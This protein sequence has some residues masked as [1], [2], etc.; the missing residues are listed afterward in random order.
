ME[1]LNRLK[2]DKATRKKLLI[3]MSIMFA[4]LIGC[5]I[6]L[7][8]INTEYLHML[9]SAFSS[10]AGGIVNAITGGSFS[11]MSVFALSVTPYITA[12]ILLQ[13]LTVI[14]PSLEKLSKS[15]S[16]GTQKMEKITL[17]ITGV[18]AVIE[19]I[20]L[21]V[22]LGKNGLFNTYNAWTVVYATVVWTIGACVLVWV[23]QMITKKFIGNGISLILLFNIL[24]TLP[25]EVMNI[26][27]YFA[28]EAS[29]E[30]QI[31]IAV[32]IAV[33]FIL[34]IAYV[35]V[36]NNAEE[37][38]HITNAN[39]SGFRMTSANDNIL[40][41]KVNMGGVMPIIFASSIMSFPVMIASIIGIESETWKKVF[42][43][44]NQSNWFRAEYM[45]TSIGAIVFVAL[46][47]VFSYFYFAISFNANEIA[48][49]LRKNGSVINGLRPGQPTADFL[50]KEAKHLLVI[51]TTMLI[52]VAMLPIVLTGVLN[53]PATSFGG[54]T[55]IIIVGVLLEMKSMLYAKTSS[56]SYKSLFKKKPIKH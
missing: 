54:T 6:P 21:A 41:L 50:A 1:L 40:P 35:V 12:S 26:W 48:E 47:Y 56:V 27:S 14:V 18:I 22:G 15:G 43:V 25:T 17:G 24:S 45:W 32:C 31:L 8:G 49:S 52:V 23:G 19:S 46:A 28:H 7:P 36:L 44:L 2:R 51:G 39:K 30:K 13:L 16:V 53:M 3:T 29:I 38:L 5:Q 11:R 37:R 34:I 55:A 4:L 9:N 33:F 42:D 20:G 10:G